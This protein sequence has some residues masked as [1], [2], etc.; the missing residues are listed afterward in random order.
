MAGRGR[1][2]PPPG[3]ER[4]AQVLD[5]VEYRVRRSTRPQLVLQC[6]GIC[7]TRLKMKAGA[8]SNDR[9]YS[10]A[11][12]AWLGHVAEFMMLP[13]NSSQLPAPSWGVGGDQPC[14]SSNL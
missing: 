10:S 14:Y 13:R 11:L 8:C 12:E 5:G 3:V 9:P 7:E 1:R 6:R 4:I 2:F